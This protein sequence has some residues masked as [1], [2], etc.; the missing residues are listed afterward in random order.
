MAAAP[1]TVDW[2]K[3]VFLFG[4]DLTDDDGNAFPDELFDQGMNA[5]L[6]WLSHAL[7]IKIP[8]TQIV[9]ERHD[10]RGVQHGEWWLID[11][12]H[13]P[14]A[15][16]E[17][18]SFKFGQ[19]EILDIPDDW[20]LEVIKGTGQIQIVPNAGTLFTWPLAQFGFYSASMLSQYGSLP[21]WYSIDYTAGYDAAELPFDL[22]D[23]AGKWA[24]GYP[25]NTAGDLIVGAGVASKST[26]LDGASQSV[27]TTSSA[28]NAG[29]GARINQYQKDIKEAIPILRRRYHGMQM[30]VV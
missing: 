29:Y 18:V 9:G 11:L 2:L 25:L 23:I 14:V 12:D 5:A 1:W 24:S 30:K 13:I 10:F 22:L 16:V 20:I 27:S 3:K 17:K 26:S 28:T 4:I 21:G 8:R 15:S 19:Q 6:A 7:D